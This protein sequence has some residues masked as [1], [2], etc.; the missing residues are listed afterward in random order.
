[1]IELYSITFEK[2][3][4]M[5]FYPLL[6]LRCE[7]V[8]AV[9]MIFLII[10][11]SLYRISNA[12][13]SSDKIFWFALG[14]VIFDIITVITVNSNKISSRINLLEI[15]TEGVSY[16]HADILNWFCHIAFY[17][18]A[19]LFLFEF[20]C[21]IINLCFSKRIYGICK[22]IGVLSIVVY[23][24]ASP[25]LEMEFIQANGTKSSYGMAAFAGYGLGIIFL[26]TSFVIVIIKRKELGPH[27]ARAILPMLSATLLMELAQIFIPEFLFT[28]AAVTITSVG[29]FF[30]LEN[31]IA[32][33][34]KQEQIDAL[35]G[36]E[37]RNIYEQSMKTMEKEYINGHSFIFVFCDLNDLKR[38]NDVYGHL[39]GDQYISDIAT[40]LRTN[41]VHYSNIFRM[42][43]DEFLAVYRDTDESVVICETDNVLDAIEE[44]NKTSV[45]PL[46]LSMGYAVF[47][48]GFNTLSDVVRSADYQMYTR[49]LEIKKAR[50]SNVSP[51]DKI[52]ITG[53]SGR[54]FDALSDTDA[55]VFYFVENINT[56]VCHW[57]R[58]AVQYFGLESEYIESFMENF[59]ET[60]HPDDRDKVTDNVK[61]CLSGLGIH[62]NVTYRLKNGENKYVTVNSKGKVIHGKS[63]EGDIFAGRLTVLDDPS[64]T[65]DYKL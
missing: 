8:C 7:I 25:F 43:G 65:Q 64:L 20:F 6:V 27:I 32:V 5:E 16:S 12:N 63:G 58:S 42:G 50:M 34:R 13:R 19:L 10:N 23:G 51:S 45:Y 62:H 38:V 53:I 9:I 2:R 52:N 26:I 49:K 54:L 41:L 40:I 11:S 22:N 47:G 28:G 15:L 39:E 17:I 44:K 1:M 24:A 60:I 31:P 55:N 35:T 46:S 21:Y 36:V 59:Y 48:K 4:L 18:F 33:F 14:H 3:L 61:E 57:S 37:T 56:G 29:F 30:S